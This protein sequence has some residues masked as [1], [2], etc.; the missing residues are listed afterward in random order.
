MDTNPAYGSS[1]KK[2]AIFITSNPAYGHFSS[3]TEL[4]A[5]PYEIPLHRDE[6]KRESQSAA[7][8]EIPLRRDKQ[9]RVPQTAASYEVP[10]QQEREHTY[11]Y[12]PCDLPPPTHI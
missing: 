4:S 5:A 3:L 6:R 1:V 12:I 7:P 2:P 8:Y 9:E 11:E 10:L